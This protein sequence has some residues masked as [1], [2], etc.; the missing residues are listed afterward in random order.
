MHEQVYVNQI[1][2]EAVKHGLVE[3]ITVEVGEL[4]AIPAHE[5]EESLKVTKWD[6]KVVMKQATVSCKCTFVGRPQITE[7]GHDFTIYHCPACGRLA[8][9]I[10][11]GKEIILKSVRVRGDDDDDWLDLMDLPETIAKQF[12][13]L[14]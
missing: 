13:K 6:V 3:G 9:A 4:A 8:P 5:L 2:K 12:S 10:L 1:I 11:D 7:K 14:I